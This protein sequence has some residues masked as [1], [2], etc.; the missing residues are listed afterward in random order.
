MFLL[1]FPSP[2]PPVPP[3][4][5]PV[6]RGLPGWGLRV[7]LV[8]QISIGGGGVP[9]Q[10]GL[11]V[12]QKAIHQGIGWV[13]VKKCPVLPIFS[14]RLLSRKMLARPGF[15]PRNKAIIRANFAPLYFPTFANLCQKV[16]ISNIY[17]FSWI[18]TVR[19]C[20]PVRG[21]LPGLSGGVLL[22]KTR[23]DFQ[24]K[25][26]SP[27]KV[28]NAYLKKHF[29]VIESCLISF[30]F[31]RSACALRICAT[32]PTMTYTWR[33]RTGFSRCANLKK[34]SFFWQALS[35]M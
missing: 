30:F 33:G 9:A 7:I 15:G 6:P 23:C 34:K 1:F 22:P 35:W 10:R 32:R 20:Y 21:T 11:R 27:I 5:H 28:K 25:S 18:G 13:S 16:Y 26:A 8:L 2:G 14:C 4:R 19:G 29:R 24:P 31:T 17:F 3:V 12:L